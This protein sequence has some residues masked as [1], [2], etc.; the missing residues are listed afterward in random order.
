MSN[1][2]PPNKRIHRKRRPAQKSGQRST[3]LYLYLAL[4]G[5]IGVVV[6]V[7]V[8]I[9]VLSGQGSD[10][11]LSA[12]VQPAAEGD[13]SDDSGDHIAA[14][15]ENRT[16]A[17]DF[18]MTLGINEASV[19][20]RFTQPD[21]GLEFA[22]GQSVEGVP[23]TM[24]ASITKDARAILIGEPEDLYSLTVTQGFA[25][26]GPDAE[27]V[28]T[29]LFEALF[30]VAAPKW[31]EGYKTFRNSLKVATEKGGSVIYNDEYAYIIRWV[32][33]LLMVG[34]YEKDEGQKVAQAMGLSGGE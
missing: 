17:P 10:A 22:A 14:T 5:G 23:S 21:A 32:S 3:P 12:P 8:L 18:S 9:A 26:A 25:G 6:T 28:D 29:S 31:D 16:L 30:D 24:G 33:P 4:A 1:D 27:L 2:Q 11:P 34:V 7:G 13:S 20:E 15:E 19:I